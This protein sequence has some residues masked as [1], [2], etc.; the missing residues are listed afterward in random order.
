MQWQLDIYGPIQTNSLCRYQ[1]YWQEKLNAWHCYEGE[2]RPFPFPR[3]DVSLET[4]AKYR[5]M[6]AGMSK[7]EG[8]RVLRNTFNLFGEK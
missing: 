4:L 1:D 5:G 3:S 8:F 2:N 6:Q 7:A